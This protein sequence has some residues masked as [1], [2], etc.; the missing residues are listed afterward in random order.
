MAIKSLKE[1]KERYTTEQPEK[2]SLWERA[3]GVWDERLGS[4][5]VQNYN[6][7]RWIRGLLIALILSIGVSGYMSTK[8]TTVPYVVTV[9]SNSGEVKN[10]GVAT[11]S[12]VTPEEA[13]LQYYVRQFITDTRRI[14]LD[15]DVY[16]S[17]WTE[18]A[19]FMTKDCFAKMT[20]DYNSSKRGEIVGKKTVLINIVS[21][22]PIES[23][24]T[25]EVHW[26]E[27][28]FVIGSGAKTVIPMRGIFTMVHL[29][30][31]DLEKVQKNPLSIYFS[32]FNWQRDAV[33]PTK[34]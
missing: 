29:P 27:E 9:D 14:P 8:N 7:R 28:E 11:E 23:G 18:A 6:Q 20:S 32:D 21:V 31:K 1:S 15:G 13:E 33:Q 26:T 5:A 10:I 25:Y 4:L 34:K 2:K 3:E 12:S 24:R 17:Q 22:L 30:Q 19:N 16:K